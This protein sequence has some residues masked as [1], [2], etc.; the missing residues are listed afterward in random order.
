MDTSIPPIAQAG[1]MIYIAPRPPMEIPPLSRPV[2][3]PTEIMEAKTYQQPMDRSFWQSDSEWQITPADKNDSGQRSEQLTSASD[4]P[5]FP[6]SFRPGSR[7]LDIL[8]RDYQQYRSKEGSY[9]Y[10]HNGTQP[11]LT[12]ASGLR[13]L[14]G[15][16]EDSFKLSLTL[17]SGAT[18]DFTLTNQTGFAKD[19]ETGTYAR[20]NQW[21]TEFSVTGEPLS[22]DDRE[23][24]AQLS[25]AFND[26]ANQY[27]STGKFSLA[28]FSPQ[29]MSSISTLSMTIQGG[30]NTAGDKLTLNFSDDDLQ[31]SLNISL[32][33]DKLN[34]SLEKTGWALVAGPEQK[35]QSLEEYLQ[36]I[37]DSAGWGN[38]SDTQLALMLDAFRLLHADEPA[39]SDTSD[40]APIDAAQFGASGAG[41]RALTGLADFSFSFSARIETP[42]DHELRLHEKIS[43][44][45]DF[46]Q[47]TRG[48]SRSTGELALEQTQ[49]YRMSASYYELLPWLDMVDFDKQ[50]YRYIETH[51]TAT[52]VTRLS[53][54]DFRLADATYQHQNEWSERQRTYILGNLDSDLRKGDANQ[55]LRD[56]SQLA[57]AGSF[58]AQSHLVD[59]LLPYAIP[60]PRAR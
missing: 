26:A 55:V 44:E 53:Y 19:K 21:V 5:T 3:T 37:R 12:E 43:F 15:H 38:G 40:R 60:S 22:D 23:Q 6:T 13:L 48:E 7:M 11:A 31:R 58:A 59:T 2:L 39:D 16:K 28:V 8:N 20:V 34:L 57:D 9:S 10:R 33:G 4:S 29:R 18:V 45:L 25:N 41:L 54:Q 14:Y 36:L 24:L 46:A 32:N 17:K 52:Q 50:N 42:N 27:L 47:D 49:A 51:A 35:D 56:F 1:T 30:N